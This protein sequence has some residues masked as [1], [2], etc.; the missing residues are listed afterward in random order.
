MQ[1]QYCSIA[2]QLSQLRRD[3]KGSIHVEADKGAVVG[4]GRAAGAVAARVGRVQHHV[5][6]VV[7][8]NV[9]VT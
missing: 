5:G 2:V 7:D 1:I 6:Q 8:G 9:Q 3:G 4:H